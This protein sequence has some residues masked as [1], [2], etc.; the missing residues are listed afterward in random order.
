MSKYSQFQEFLYSIRGG[1]M[2]SRV[3]WHEQF[4]LI[5]HRE[6][7]SITLAGCW[8]GEGGGLA[9]ILTMLTLCF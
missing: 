2:A 7:P 5:G 6:A 9:N 8:E 1:Y 4:P 3:Y